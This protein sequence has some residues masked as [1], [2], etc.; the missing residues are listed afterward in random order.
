MSSKVS[1]FYLSV[2]ALFQHRLILTISTHRVSYNSVSRILF[3]EI[4]PSNIHSCHSNWLTNQLD[5]MKDDGFITKDERR[6]LIIR[7][8][9]SK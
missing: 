8:D 5:D 4:M 9:T 3:V 1:V 2:I 6:R 7:V